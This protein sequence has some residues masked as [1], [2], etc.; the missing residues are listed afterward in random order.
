MGISVFDKYRIKCTG[1]FSY[2]TPSYECPNDW[3]TERVRWQKTMEGSLLMK[4]IGRLLSD[5]DIIVVSFNNN[6]ITTE[7]YKPDGSCADCKYIIERLEKH[8][9]EQK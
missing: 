9:K 4:F 3:H 8:S 6:T 1:K 2:N 5:E 7:H